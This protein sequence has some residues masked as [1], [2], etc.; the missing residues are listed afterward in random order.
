MDYDK[1]KNSHSTDPSDEEA[2][3]IDSFVDDDDYDYSDYDDY[4]DIHVDNEDDWGFSD[5]EYSDDDS[6]VDLFSEESDNDSGDEVIDPDDVIE[7]S[8]TDDEDGAGEDSF[9][10]DNHDAEETDYD[11]DYDYEDTDVDWDNV[12]DYDLDNLDYSDDNNY[13]DFDE[14]IVEEQDTDSTEADSEESELEEYVAPPRS[15]KKK[16]N[17]PTQPEHKKE[18]K[19]AKSEKSNPKENDKEDSSTEEEKEAD[20]AP[21]GDKVVA[22]ISSLMSR[23]KSKNKDSNTNKDTDT[24]HPTVDMSQVSDHIQKF[25]SSYKQGCKQVAEKLSRIPILGRIFGA[26]ESKPQFLPLVIIVFIAVI[27]FAVNFFT[28]PSSTSTVLLPDEGEVEVTSTGFNKEDDTLDIEAENI[29]GVIIPFDEEM[30]LYT[31][32]PTINPMSWFG[33]K[34]VG[35]CVIKGLTVEDSTKETVSCTVDSDTG[36]RTR[37]VIEQEAQEE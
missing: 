35:T 32:K 30:K 21:I 37:G 19:K 16:K 25:Y 3:D 10:V 22:A 23:D 2:I 28:A 13:D 14:D 33:F 36:W 15:G 6:A 12:E 17:K 24:K 9:E 7:D 4:S 11:D 18:K 1:I 31:Y 8:D 20:S 29:G 5:E 26:L 34:E 27:V